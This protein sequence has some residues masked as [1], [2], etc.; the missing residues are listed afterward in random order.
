MTSPFSPTSSRDSANI[1]VFAGLTAFCI[2]GGLVLYWHWLAAVPATEILANRMV[3]SLVAVVPLVVFTGR[4]PEVRAALASPS[5]MLRIAL[6]ASIIGGNWGLYIWAVTQGHVLESSLGYF[7]N[8]LV[9]VLLGTLFL[10]ERPTRLQWLAIAIASFGVLWSVLALGVFPWIALTLAVSFSL[11]G[12][13][14]KTVRV[15]SVPGL[16]LETLLLFPLAAG[17]L[18]WLHSQG[19]SHFTSI[20]LPITLLLMGTGLAT[21]VPLL[22]FA[23]AARHMQLSTLGLL[24]YVSP[25]LTFLIGAFVLG[26]T[27]TMDALITFGCIWVALGI[28]T[29]CAV[30]T[31][32]HG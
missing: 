6:S 4:I 21:S 28:Y 19:Q 30:R 8:P 14:R 3:W 12:F 16:F 31:Y 1:G 13:C 2:W 5:T 20:S 17:W 29:W 23:Y 9:N 15:E 32:K 27:L 26:E 10:G 11:Y 25:T 7:I 24:Q 22:L 18:L